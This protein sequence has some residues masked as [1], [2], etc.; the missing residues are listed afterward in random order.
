MDVIYAPMF[1]LGAAC[2]FESL[3]G[4]CAEVFSTLGKYSTGMWFIHAIFFV[5]YTKDFFQPIMTVVKWP[6]LM[7]VW[8]VVLSLAG[9]YFF[10]KCLDLIHMIP[11][12]RKRVS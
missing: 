6:P 8:L 10:R 1:I 11:I 2:F 3:K 12:H 7:Y 9:A 5:T 4:K